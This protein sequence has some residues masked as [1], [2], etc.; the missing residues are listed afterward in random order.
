MGKWCVMA[1]V[2]LGLV[3]CR[4]D[5][6]STRATGE[7]VA[8]APVVPPPVVEAAVPPAPKPTT[9]VPVSPIRKGVSREQCRREFTA[10]CSAR[11]RAKDRGDLDNTRKGRQVEA[12][13]CEADCARQAENGCPLPFVRRGRAAPRAGG[14]GRAVPRAGGRELRRHLRGAEP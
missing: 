5:K 12:K 13:L 8:A 9:V 3:G 1:L 4:G 14:R 2:V 6:P 10:T 7:A 11:C